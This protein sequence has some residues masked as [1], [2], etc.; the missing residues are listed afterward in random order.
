MF[1]GSWI[2]VVMFLFLGVVIGGFW[3]GGFERGFKVLVVFFEFSLYSV[4][5]DGVVF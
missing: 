4:W 1:V 5:F 3:L 2:V